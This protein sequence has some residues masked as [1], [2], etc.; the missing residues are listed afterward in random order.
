MGRTECHS[1]K[2]VHAFININYSTV[3]LPR[4]FQTISMHLVTL[5]GLAV[6]RCIRPNHQS[7]PMLPACK[8][9]LQLLQPIDQS[10]QVQSS[11]NGGGRT[12]QEGAAPQKQLVLKRRSYQ[13]GDLSAGTKRLMAP[14]ASSSQ[15]VTFNKLVSCILDCSNCGTIITQFQLGATDAGCIQHCRQPR[16]TCA[17]HRN[18][19]MRFTVY[20]FLNVLCVYNCA[21][22][23]Q[24]CLHTPSLPSPNNCAITVKMHRLMAHIPRFTRL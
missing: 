17:L 19:T 20:S 15:P 16:I 5:S 6:D 7:F 22:K 18:Q 9:A 1:K 24:H 11:E 21:A 2:G 10:S 3:N 8:S 4:L 12:Q 13:P 23:L 14:A